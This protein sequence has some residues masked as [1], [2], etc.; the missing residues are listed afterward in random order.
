MPLNII[1]NAYQLKTAQTA[2][3]VV[4][5]HLHGKFGKSGTRLDGHAKQVLALLKQA[6]QTVTA[7]RDGMSAHYAQLERRM[8]A[9]RQQLLQL[10]IQRADALVQMQIYART[11]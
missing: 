10:G 3:Q 2:Y 4:V 6:I 7:G 11:A 5:R 9:A 8:A 1:V